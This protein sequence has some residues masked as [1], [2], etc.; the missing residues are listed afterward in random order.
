M[1]EKPILAPPVSLTSSNHAGVRIK[2]IGNANHIENNH[3]AK[4]YTPEFSKAGVTAARRVAHYT[5]C[6]QVISHCPI[7][8][9]RHTLRAFHE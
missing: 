3:F 1:A 6:G 5:V 4:I 2:D 7:A 9:A 8:G